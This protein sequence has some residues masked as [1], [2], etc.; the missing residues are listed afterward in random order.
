MLFGV[1]LHSLGLAERLA[2]VEPLKT[3]IV[4]KFAREWPFVIFAG[5]LLLIGLFVER[6]YCRYLC[7][8]GAALAIPARIATFRWLKRYRQ[9]GNPCQR[10]ANDCMV[11]AIT[12]EGEINLN[13]CQYCLHC[14][15]L[16]FDEHNCP[17]VIARVA[18]RERQRANVSPNTDQRIEAI[19]DEVRKGRAQRKESDATP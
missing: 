1:S 14:Q 7:G 8:L 15:K 19:L 12:P 6:F 3:A 17:V 5:G 18:K 2:E 10:C 9:C 13:E 11:Q 16:Y 4:L